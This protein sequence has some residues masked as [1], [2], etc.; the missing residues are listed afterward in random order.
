VEGGT[1]RVFFFYY[2][3]LKATEEG[4]E[5]S[6]FLKA[7]NNIIFEGRIH[8]LAF[9]IHPSHN[10]RLLKLDFDD[11]VGLSGTQNLGT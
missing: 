3:L 7:K 6:K 5:P 4:V 9:M 8:S 2:Y 10:L 11:H 1:L